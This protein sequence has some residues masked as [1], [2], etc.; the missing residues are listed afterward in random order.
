[1]YERWP[2]S[3]CSPSGEEMSSATC[4]ETNRDSSVRWRSTASSRRA[5]AIAIAAWSAKA[6]KSSICSSLNGSGTV[7]TTPSTPSSSS[8]TRIGTP[9]S[10][11]Y[12]P[13]R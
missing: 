12:P 11:R 7:R 2:A 9:T 8:S 3:S 13:R 6:R 10:E 1:M 4:G 5:L